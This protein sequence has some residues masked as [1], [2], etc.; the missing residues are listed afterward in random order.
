MVKDNLIRLLR[1][2]IVGKTVNLINKS[3]TSVVGH[4]ISTLT[5]LGVDI[6][7]E[8]FIKN[9]TSSTTA[10]T[11][12]LIGSGDREES[13]DEVYLENPI[14]EHYSICNFSVV[15]QK[16]S[17][18]SGTLI[19]YSYIMQNTGQEDMTINEIGLAC[20]SSKDYN[21]APTDISLLLRKKLEEPVVLKNG[22][23][24]SFTLQIII[25]RE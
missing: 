9:A 25:G 15:E 3:N 20:T 22:E 8:E 2:T 7:I 17:D 19:M 10:K 5:S 16:A 4:T 12:F 23:Y 6:N 21:K 1:R 18:N 24:H 11:F 14:Y 13:E